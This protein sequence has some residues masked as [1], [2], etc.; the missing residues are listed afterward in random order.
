MS[1]IRLEQIT[2]VA[3]PHA[4]QGHAPGQAPGPEHRHRDRHLSKMG[5]T[6]PSGSGGV[7]LLQRVG[8]L[9]ARRDGDH[10]Y[11]SDR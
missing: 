8:V 4:R 6:E 3:G 5:V 9:S 10:R 11:S 7:R 2:R 1:S